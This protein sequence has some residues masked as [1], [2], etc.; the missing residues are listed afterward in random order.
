[1]HIFICARSLADEH[2][3]RINVSNPEYDIFALRGKVL[4]FDA[5]HD[6]LT[7]FRERCGFGFRS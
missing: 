5:L 3:L 1:L 2:D 6:P 7:Q 4:A